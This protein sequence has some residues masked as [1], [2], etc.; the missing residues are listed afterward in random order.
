MRSNKKLE[1]LLGKDV[2]TREEEMR[3]FAQ[4][5]KSS[6]PSKVVASLERFCST[7]FQLG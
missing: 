3:V 4:L 5:W 1:A 6:D 7:E 2:V